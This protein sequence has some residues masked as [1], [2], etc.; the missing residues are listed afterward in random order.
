MAITV[1]CPDCGNRKNL[2]D[3]V[4]G[5][6]LRCRVCSA[7][8]FHQWG[9]NVLLEPGDGTS[10]TGMDLALD[11]EFMTTS[12]GVIDAVS[13]SGLYRMVADVIDVPAEMPENPTVPGFV[14]GDRIGEGGMGVVFRAE[15]ESDGA[16]FA[17]KFL[18][19]AL[20]R[21]RTYVQRFLLEGEYAKKLNH[22]NIVSYHEFGSHEGLYYIVMELVEGDSVANVLERE[23]PFDLKRTIDLMI[24][25]GEGLLH[26]HQHGLI[27]RDLKP[28]NVLISLDGAPRITDF[29]LV[30][31][32]G[33]VY[34]L[35]RNYIPS[36]GQV[37]RLERVFTKRLKKLLR[38][39][40]DSSGAPVTKEELAEIR[41]EVEEIDA[42]P[43]LGED[44]DDYE[45]REAKLSSA[46]DSSIVLGTV[47]YISPE[48]LEGKSLDPLTDIYSFGVMF[49]HCL[50][51]EFPF[52]AEDSE[53]VLFK[54]LVE[55][56]AEIESFNPELKPASLFVK[57]LIA[58]NRSHRYPSMKL[59]LED[60]LRLRDG[61]PLL[62][63]LLA[64][65]DA[66]VDVTLAGIED[67]RY[68]H[69]YDIFE[70]IL[71][72]VRA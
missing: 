26:A 54:K 12:D 61:A 16:P 3:H 67:V 22:P 41:A 63:S 57:R 51:G 47:P 17:V 33:E 53:G 5:L 4:I 49:Y 66:V 37:V 31:D 39:N 13:D 72:L 14:V 10:G 34:D 56:P 30:K 15:R 64:C 23:G 70:T 25:V 59:V 42:E 18:S 20:A 55:E 46:S 24:G 1:E 50:T 19:L 40:L 71:H 38:Q 68:Q 32:L 28:D 7:I 45:E 35:T 27:H 52:D 48:Q 69:V 36:A 6:R 62:Y 9:K 11:P 60:L 58:R 2:G 43:F 21:N 8:F 65:Y 29:G 44:E